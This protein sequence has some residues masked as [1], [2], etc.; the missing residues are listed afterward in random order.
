MAMFHYEIMFMKDSL[1]IR[2]VIEKC[3]RYD[4]AWYEFYN[5]YTHVEEKIQIATEN[6]LTRPMYIIS[7]VKQIW[8]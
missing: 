3:I 7:L 5:I 2:L 4:I 6:I 8:F 1:I